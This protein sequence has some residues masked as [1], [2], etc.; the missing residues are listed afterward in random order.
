LGVNQAI[1]RSRGGLTTKMAITF[2]CGGKNLKSLPVPSATIRSAMHLYEQTPIV[3]TQ[4]VVGETKQIE[5]TT[6]CDPFSLCFLVHAR[7]L[8]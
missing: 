2:E 8:V 3:K 1:G 6:R 5:R 4:A 7:Y